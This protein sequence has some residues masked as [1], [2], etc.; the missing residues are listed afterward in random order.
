M[1][2]FDSTLVQKKLCISCK[3]FL[4]FN[5]QSKGD[6]MHYY[7]YCNSK[8][9]TANHAAA[10]Q[11]F[12]KRLSAYCNTSFIC[13]ESIS[14]P[15]NINNTNHEIIIIS[16]QPSTYSSEEFSRWIHQ[17]QLN[18]KSNIHIFIGYAENDVYP[19]LASL[20]EYI[21]PITFSLT[22]CNLSSQT[23]AI[24]CYEQLYRGYTILQGKT[25]H[26]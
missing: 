14:L 12:E 5:I 4:D 24:L 26:K 23:K 6:F 20:E 13:S 17:M 11:E 16:E 9:I 18:G 19:V 3:A 8:K 1:R 25:Y 7:I 2:W 22:R 10:I 15:Q 21:T